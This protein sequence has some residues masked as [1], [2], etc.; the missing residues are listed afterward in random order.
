M[1][2]D[3]TL[4]RIYGYTG[5]AAEQFSKSIIGKSDYDYA[6]SISRPINDKPDVVQ[7]VH[8]TAPFI[9]KSMDEGKLCDVIDG[10]SLWSIIKFGSMCHITSFMGQPSF[11]A[12]NSAAANGGAKT[13]HIKAKV[14]SCAPWLISNFGI[15]V[16]PDFDPLPGGFP[17]IPKESRR[18]MAIKFCKVED[19]RD[20]TK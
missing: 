2:A 18:K 14:Y 9:K 8:E 5:N 20:A 15:A 7:M 12:I 4:A 6:L 11:V 16:M 13:S 3:E 19:I 10:H 17:E 1:N